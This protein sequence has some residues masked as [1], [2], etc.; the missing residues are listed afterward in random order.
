MA[1]FPFG[2][3]LFGDINLPNGEH[4]FK[5][6]KDIVRYRQLTILMNGFAQLNNKVME[7]AAAKTREQMRGWSLDDAVEEKSGK[8]KTPEELADEANAELTKLRP[9]R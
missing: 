7:K 8:K 1:V 4:C 3:V 2:W 9:L 6:A 5:K